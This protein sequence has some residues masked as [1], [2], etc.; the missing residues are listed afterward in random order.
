MKDATPVD[1]SAV[2]DAARERV[3]SRDRTA[4]GERGTGD[5]DDA[6]ESDAPS[7][8]LGDDVTIAPTA[9]VPPAGTDGDG[10][11]VGDGATVRGGTVIYPDVEIGEDFATG[12][13]A[14]VREATLIGDDVLVGTMAVI[15]G[16]V[17][18]G[19]GTS[20]QTG[21]YVPAHSN[22][23][24]RVFLGPN[25]TLTNDPWPVR[26]D[27]TTLEGPRLDDDVTVG[28]NA[29]ILPDVRVG[30]GAFVA[31]GAIVTEDVP[32]RTLAIGAP[33]EFRELPEDLEGGN[34]L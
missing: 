23:G 5:V 1:G 28:A 31:A 22:L 32:P 2:E 16:N 19:D 26:D 24:K 8:Q 29:T 21:A 11:V 7:P 33:A 15:D 9:E 18:I 30:V 13:D 3:G 25:A 27:D 17:R 12:H 20:L 10:P 34:E 4:R 6:P 14:V